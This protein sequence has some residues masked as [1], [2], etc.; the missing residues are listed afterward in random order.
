MYRYTYIYIYMYVYIY[1][2]IYILLGMHQTRPPAARQLLVVCADVRCTLH[3]GPKGILAAGGPCCGGGEDNSSP[4]GA[5]RLASG[6]MGAVVAPR[7]RLA[8]LGICL[9]VVSTHRLRWAR[10]GPGRGP[11]T[12]QIGAG[13]CRPT[14]ADESAS[15]G[16]MGHLELFRCGPR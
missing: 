16:L 4:Q 8:K 15:G 13:L 11:R 10:R 12:L 14:C 3:P 9:S 7:V 5:T 2:Y 1:I 6:D